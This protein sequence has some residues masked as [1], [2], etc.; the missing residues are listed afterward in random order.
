MILGCICAWFA[1]FKEGQVS[2]QFIHHCQ[3]RES[4]GDSEK[5]TS[6]CSRIA[7][8]YR[9][10]SWRKNYNGIKNKTVQYQ[11]RPN[12]VLLGF[13]C[14]DDIFN[15]WTHVCPLK[16]LNDLPNRIVPYI[17]PDKCGGCWQA[18]VGCPIVQRLSCPCWDKESGTTARCTSSQHHSPVR[19]DRWASRK[20]TSVPAPQRT[21]GN[22]ASRATPLENT[23]YI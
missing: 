5:L 8:E 3:Q 13:E 20:N 2:I 12:T 15:F 21:P 18:G 1:V 23:W 14:P 10:N 4:L 11:M 6:C 16:M 22:E 17:T 9:E 19:P 7:Q